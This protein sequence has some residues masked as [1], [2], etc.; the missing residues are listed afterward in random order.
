MLNLQTCSFQR[1]I[2]SILFSFLLLLFF[3]LGMTSCRKSNPE[4]TVQLWVSEDNP[5]YSSLTA[6]VGEYNRQIRS[7]DL[8][9]DDHKGG[10]VLY[11]KRE[12]VQALLDES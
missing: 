6:A 2:L 3:C 8:L 10:C 1:R 9:A 4:A 7:G 12:Q 5:L 11:E